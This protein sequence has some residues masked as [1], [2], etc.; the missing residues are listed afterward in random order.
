MSTDVERFWPM[1][2]NV[3]FEVGTRVR[4]QRLFLHWKQTP[5]TVLEVDR[6]F[7]IAHVEFDNGRRAW[8]AIPILE[9]FA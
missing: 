1:I 4:T 8:V 2:G 5:G 6:Y 9:V 3:R 7:G